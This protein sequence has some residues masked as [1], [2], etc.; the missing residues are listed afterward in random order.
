MYLLSTSAEVAY[1]SKYK[2]YYNHWHGHD[3]RRGVFLLYPYH[4]AVLYTVAMDTIILVIKYIVPL[5]F[6]PVVG[7]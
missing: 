7:W 6:Y 5:I 3:K 2:D 4:F 1:S